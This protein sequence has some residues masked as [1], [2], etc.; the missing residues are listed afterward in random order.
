MGRD[1]ADKIS[2]FLVMSLAY[3][4]HFSPI[5]SEAIRTI[6]ILELDSNGLA[7]LLINLL[8]EH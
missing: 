7:F 6:F 3:P 5:F 4:F 1:I 8:Y 2:I